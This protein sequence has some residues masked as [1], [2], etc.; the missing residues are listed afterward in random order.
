MQDCK[1]PLPSIGIGLRSNYLEYFLI[2]IPQI[3]IGWLEVHPENYLYHYP[4]RHK[5]LKISE[6]L[7]LSFHCVTLS[8]GSTELPE[9][10]HLMRLKQLMDDV[11]PF[12]V[13]DH[14]SWNTLGHHSYNDLYPLPLT[15]ESLECVARNIQIVQDVLN[16]PL[17]IENPSTY[18]TYKSNDY[19]EYEFLNEVSQTTGCG[20]LL[21]LN[22]VYVQSINHQWDVGSYMN[23]MDWSKV[24]EFHLAGH[25]QSTDGGF[26]IDTHNRPVCEAV[27]ELYADAIQRQPNAKTLIEWDDDLPDIQVLFDHA[28][29]A[30]AVSVGSYV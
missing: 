3:P 8:L 15:F 30:A 22:N 26:L 21:D 4:N 9:R 24:H 13:S 20:I 18:V 14:L 25:I 11:Q 12:M 17:L 5:L 23:G 10:D 6:K 27:W 7:P 2:D 16:R 19:M 1:N 29:K 28:E